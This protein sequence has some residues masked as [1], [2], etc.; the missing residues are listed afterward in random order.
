MSFP[1]TAVEADYELIMSPYE[2]DTL[3]TEV[4]ICFDVLLQYYIQ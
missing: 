2:A 3:V 1:L 4:F